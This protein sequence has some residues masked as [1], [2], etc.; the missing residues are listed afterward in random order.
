[1][2]N[3]D[4]EIAAN[5]HTDNMIAFHPE[6]INPPSP[7]VSFLLRVKSSQANIP[8]LS[9][10]TLYSKHSLQI[11]NEKSQVPSPMAEDVVFQSCKSRIERNF[12]NGCF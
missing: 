2:Q 11:F 9:L 12:V 5:E 6:M 7:S 4:N 10:E 3:A 1:L 8:S